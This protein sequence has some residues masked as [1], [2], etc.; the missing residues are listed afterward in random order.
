MILGFHV[1]FTNENLI[2]GMVSVYPGLL[3]QYSVDPQRL[4]V[5]RGS[6]SPALNIYSTCVKLG[7]QGA[8]SVTL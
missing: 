8:K 1:L 3:G 7:A 5:I 6:T 4:Q 2:G